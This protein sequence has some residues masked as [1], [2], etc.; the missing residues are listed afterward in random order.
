ML[1][2]LTQLTV[3]IGFCFAAWGM[4]LAQPEVP[5]PSVPGAR[6][7]IT[8]LLANTGFEINGDGDNL[9]DSWAGKGTDLNKPDKIKCDKPEKPVAHSGSC[10][11]MFSGNPAGEKTKIQQTIT[12]FSMIGNGTMLTFGAYVDPRSG[13]PGA[14]FGKAV[15]KMSDDTKT[16]FELLIPSAGS[17]YVQVTSTNT[18]TVMPSA[19]IVKVK[20]GFV[21]GQTGGKFAIDD[22]SFAVVDNSV[23]ATP[24][25]TETPT[26]TLTPTN[27]PTITATPIPPDSDTIPGSGGSDNFGFAVAIDGTTLVVGAPSAS[28]TAGQYEGMVYVYV[29]DGVTWVLQDSFTGDDSDYAD[30]FGQSVDIDGDTLIVGAPF[31]GNG[32]AAYV[33]TRSGS[34]WT[35]Q[36]KLTAQG[37]QYSSFARSVA[38]DGDTAVIGGGHDDA[39]LTDQGAA[40]I[41][42]RSGSTWTFAKRLYD[43]DPTGTDH[44]G[45]DVD[46]S[47]NTVLIGAPSYRYD[48]TFTGAAYVYTGSGS[49]WTLQQQ[50]FDKDYYAGSLGAK[51]ALQDDTAII[52]SDIGS[53]YVYAFTRSGSVW[54]QQARFTGVD[55]AAN[56]RFGSDVALDG[57]WLVIGATNVNVGQTLN[58]G[59]VYLYSG[60]GGNWTFQTKIVV[61]DGEEEDYLGWAV[62]VSQSIVAMGVPHDDVGGV[63]NRGSVRVYMIP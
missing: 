21:Y 47:G 38:I 25:L 18:V 51:V 29:W 32:G 14:K 55:S 59:A 41:F 4:A 28:Y 2:R 62:A 10:A 23:T 9:P 6:V 3:V 54:T 61:I 57:I 30:Y 12:D 5:L 40:Y 20:V 19:S 11:F 49:N 58:Q 45:T 1:K 27:T 60:S 13:T 7:V 35:Q 56:D 50:L 31:N 37:G 43:E 24:T 22:V 52:T 26:E 48:D 39:I 36:G 33:F 53:G 8:E 17:G 16:K 34:T 63:L 44:F 15:I 42:N 46:I